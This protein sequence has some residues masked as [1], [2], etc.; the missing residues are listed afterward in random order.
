MS[1]LQQESLPPSVSSA[2]L[3]D[4]CLKYFNLIEPSK[5][6]ES[7]HVVSEIKAASKLDFSVSKLI[8]DNDQEE[9]GSLCLSSRAR[10]RS[11]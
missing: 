6:E 3:L 8:S 4:F 5:C 2:E 11:Y 9:N 7:S 10:R 1:Y